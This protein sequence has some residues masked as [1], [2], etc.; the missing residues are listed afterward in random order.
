MPLL[1]LQRALEQYQ[2]VFMTS[3]NLAPR[4]RVE[5]LHDLEDL[6]GFLSAREIDRADQGAGN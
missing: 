3:R 2:Q 6:L 1:T 5:Y 4:T